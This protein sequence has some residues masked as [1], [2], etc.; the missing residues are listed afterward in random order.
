[1]YVAVLPDG[2]NQTPLR[3]VHQAHRIVERF[4]ADGVGPLE[5]EA[6]PR[7]GGTVIHQPP[8]ACGLVSADQDSVLFF[9]GSAGG[10]APPPHLGGGGAPRRWRAPGVA[11][12]FLGGG[13][14][15]FRFFP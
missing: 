8:S 7:V 12:L 15:P 9:A 13:A 14:P 11:P 5:F 2:P 6:D 10:G 3:I 4:L 1:M